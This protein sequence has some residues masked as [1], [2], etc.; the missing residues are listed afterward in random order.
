MEDEKIETVKNWPKL[1]FMRDIQ[2]FLDF[3]NFY[4]HFI[5]GF[6]K[7]ARSLTLMLKTTS[8][9]SL[10][11][12]LQSLIDT[13][14]KYKVD[15]GENSGNKTNLSNPFVSKRSTRAGYLNF[16]G[17][18]RGSGKTKKG[19]KGARGFNYLTLVAKKVFNHL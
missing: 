14:D 17:A 18:K 2:G 7:K 8:L 15:G 3:A 16:G 9:T 10:S 6:S 5:Q 11:T 4:Q 19:V 1:K 12:I 13:T